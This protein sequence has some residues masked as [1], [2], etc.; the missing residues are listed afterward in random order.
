MKNA[1]SAVLMILAMAVG[2]TSCK[3]DSPAD[4]ENALTVEQKLAGKWA[5]KTAIGNYNMF[6]NKRT[7][8]TRFSS[9]DYIEFK[10]DGTVDILA[11]TNA[12]SGKWKVLNNKLIFSDTNYIDYTDGYSIPV[13]T[14]H[15]LQLY[16]FESNTFQST[17]E[18]L[19]LA[20]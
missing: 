6:G 14:G 10:A 12:Y 7:D 13:L 1:I 3:K 20:R 8:T 19:I 2:L 9:S 4:T 11:S 17:E 16:Y 5:L 15:E 18:K